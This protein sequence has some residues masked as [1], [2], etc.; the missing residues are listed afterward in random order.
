M[1]GKRLVSGL[2]AAS[3][4]FSLATQTS[5]ATEAAE[6]AS[7]ENGAYFDFEASE[8][9][10]QE[11]AG[12]LQVKVIRHGGTRGPV[13]VAFKAAD[14]LSSYGTD[15]AVLDENGAVLP[16]VAGE[17]PD[18]SDFKSDDEDANVIVTP[19]PAENEPAASEPMASE[20]A[21]TEPA[22]PE[23]TGAEPVSPEPA[24]E[25]SAPEPI[26]GRSAELEPAQAQVAEE[27]PDESEP[28]GQ[29][30]ENPQPVEPEPA[31][32]EPTQSEPG[33]SFA[34]IASTPPDDSAPT[35]ST[36]AESV[37]AE[38]A[39][40]P[41]TSAV[42]PE[43][44]GKKRVSTG[45]P[46]LDAQAAYLNLPQ[47][48]N[49]EEA[50]GAIQETLGDLYAYF[51]AAE[52]AKGTLHFR[53]GESEKYLT[54]EI[55]DNDR[56]ESS[57]V[58]MLAL[59]G[60]STENTTIAANAT[61]YVTIVDDEQAETARF[62]LVDGG[63]TLTP[64]QPEGT[65]TIRRTAGTQYFATVYVSTVKQTA[66]TGSYEEYHDKSVG[67]VPG[68]T[69]KQIKVRACDF[70]GGGTFGIR[71]E[72]MSDVEIG[73]HYVNVN[74]QRAPKDAAEEGIA[75]V[76]SMAGEGE[77]AE[78]LASGSYL[79]SASY[80][81]DNP[82]DIPG[83][84]KQDV[85][86][87]GK[88][89]E[90][91]Q[92]IYVK[93]YTKNRYSMMA[94]KNKQ[95]LVGVK[96]IVFYAYV[97]NPSRGFKTKYDSYDT[98]FETDSDQTFEG[99]LDS[100][101][102]RGNSDWQSRTLS[103][104]NSGDSAYLKFST[105]PTSNGY[106]NSQA[107]L[108]Y[109]Q[110]NYACYTFSGQASAENFNRK[111]YDFTQGTPNVY[112]TYW[113]GETSRNYN[114]GGVT[115]TKSDG[116]ALDGFYGNNG[117]IVTITAANE[118]RNKSKGIYLKGV[119]FTT[120][121]M[122]AHTLYLNGKYTGKNV[123]YAAAE[124]GKVTFKADTAFIK[125]LRDNGV[126]GNVHSDQAINVFPVFAQEQVTVNFQNTDRDDSKAESRGK[127]D[128]SH[129]A[130]HIVNILEAYTAGN[131]KKESASSSSAD[132]YY[133][134]VPKYSVIRVQTQPA[135]TRTANGV[136]YWTGSNSKNAKTVYY[137]AGTATF[138][139]TVS[140]GETITQNDYTKADIVASATPLTIMP[141][142]GKQTFDVSYFP[143]QDI[144]DAFQGTHGLQNSVFLSDA[145]SED[146]VDGG[147]YQIKNQK[148]GKYLVS[149]S[150]R[151]KGNVY[152]G[153]YIGEGR[154]LWTII[155]H[156]DGYYNLVNG[157]GFYLDIDNASSA[158]EANVQ[159]WEGNGTI[160]QDF[161]LCKQD[162]GSFAI[163]TRTTSGRSALEVKNGST[164]ITANVQQ[165]TFSGDS[166]QKW[167]LEFQGGNLGT[168]E[169]G[170]YAFEAPFI[171]MNWSL[172][173][174][175]P[176][177]YYTQWVNMTG[178]TDGNGY[179]TEE[180]RLA[181]RGQSQTMPDEVYGNTLAGQL[182][183]DNFKL[184]YYFLPKT[185]GGSGQKTGSV[186]RASETFYQLANHIRSSDPAIPVAAAYVDVG[187]FVTQTDGNGKYSVNCSDFPAAG[188]VTTRIT[189]DDMPFYTISKLQRNTPIQLP[190]LSK[191]SAVSADASYASKSGSINGDFITVEDDQLT[192]S[193]TVE[194]SSAIIPTRA[195]FFIYDGDVELYACEGRA[196][197]AVSGETMGNQY[198][199]SLTFNPSSD[200]RMGCKIYVQFADQ[201]NEWT[202]KIDL[203]Y[204]FFTRV[205][206]DEFVFPLIGSS[207]LE[208]T[209]TE[210]VVADIIGNPLGDIKIG[211]ISGFD[212]TSQQYT[213]AGIN[214]EDAGDYTWQ[215]T[216][217][218]FGWSKEFG[219][220]SKTTSKKKYEEKLKDYLKDVYDGKTKG[221]EPPQPSKYATKSSFKW[222]VTPNV[223]F[224]LRLSTRKDTKTYFEDLMFYVK[225]DFGV[226]TSQT[227]QLPIGISILIGA[228]LNGNMAGVYHMYT[229]YWDSYETEDAVEYTSEDFGLFKKFNNS[230]RRE[231]YIFLD[232]T[233]S[234]KL[235]VGY[236]IVF[237]TGKADFAFDMDF[238]FTEIGNKSYGDMAI[239]LGWGIEL[240]GFEVYSKTLYSPS[241]KL[242]NS[243]G[244][245][246]HIDFD[247]ANR[248]A[249]QAVNEY[250][251]ADSDAPLT[252]NQPTSRAYLANQSGWLGGQASLASVD[253]SEATVEQTLKQGSG[254]APYVRMEEFGNGCILMV[255][256]GDD[257]A[258]PVSANKRALYYT[259]YDGAAWS[260]AKQVDPDGTADDYPT[261]CDLGDGRILVSWS[262][263]EDQ[264]TDGASVG[265]VMKTMNIKTAFFDT[266]TRTMG[267]AVQVTKTTE[268]D[269][270][271][272][273]LPNAAYDSA[274]GTLLLYYT[275]TEYDD[276]A[277]LNDI[278][279]EEKNP[280][281][282]AY[283]FY[284]NGK[285]SDANDYTD[286]ELNGMTE[287]AKVKYKEDWYGQRFLDLRLDKTS[288]KMPRVADTGAIS[289]DGLGLFA[290]TVDW[291]RDLNTVDDRDVFVQIYNFSE[292]SFTHI[293]RITSES[294]AYAAP[295]F[296]RSNNAT[297]LF[298]GEQD[299]ES[300]H[301]AIRCLNISD[302]VKNDKLTLK[303]EGNN[304]Y[305]VLQYTRQAEGETP[306]ETVTVEPWTAVSCDNVGDYDVKVGGDGQMYLLWTDGSGDAR[307]IM[308]AVY[309]GTDED[310]DEQQA[311]GVVLPAQEW[312]EA[313]ALTDA[314]PDTCY[315][316][317]GGAVVGGT[318]FAAGVKGSYT[319][320]TMADLV[321][322][323]HTPF[324]RL[325]ADALTL[326][327]EYPQPLSTVDVIAMVKN[328][329]L[330]GMDASEESPVTVTF[331][332][333][334]EIIGQTRI[335]KPIAGGTT[336]TAAC[337]VELPE[338]ISNVTF[339]A[340]VD[341]AAQAASLKLV[342]A[343]NVE[344][345]DSLIQRGDIDG[346][347][348]TAYTA[349]MKNSGNAPSGSITLRAR[350]G[351]TTISTLTLEPLEA[352][353]QREVEFI[354]D[355]SDSLYDINEEGSGSV[356]VEI[357]ATSGEDTITSFTGRAQKRFSAEAVSLLSGMTDV[358][359]NGTY[360]LKPYEEKEI[361]PQISG[362]SAE[363]L[364]VQWL[365]STDTDVAYINFD[366]EIVAGNAGSATVNG[367]IVP[368]IDMQVANQ[369][370]TVERVDWTALI[371]SNKLVRVTATINV[372]GS[373]T[374]STDEP[375]EP[376][377][378]VEPSYPVGP[379][380]PSGSSIPSTPDVKADTQENADGSTTTTVINSQTGAVTETTTWKNGIKLE[381]ITNKA[382][383]E[384]ISVTVPAAMDTATVTIPTKQALT[385]GT[386]AAVIHEDGTQE[387][388]KWS[389]Q[390]GDKLTVRLKESAKLKLIDNTK[391]FND[392]TADKWFADPVNFATSRELFNGTGGG[393]FSPLMAM[394][395]GMLVTVL[396]RLENGPKGSEVD[397][398]DVPD[399]KFYTE[400]VAWAAQNGI[401]NGYADGRFAPDETITREQLA[402]I[403]YRYAGQPASS[404]SISDFV[405]AEKVSSYANAALRWSVAQGIITGKEGK[406]LDPQGQAT[407]AEVAAMLQRFI[408]KE[409]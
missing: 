314:Q 237:V 115:I 341:N 394:T 164:W 292:D 40:V 253:G 198:T 378:P 169:S 400:A 161:Q 157:N 72:G 179:I 171:G 339:A 123:Y 98:Y 269:Y 219:D 162:D 331:T 335:T 125:A 150:G 333:N 124:N 113:D 401:V 241:V 73:N 22:S 154:G 270:A 264:F 197:Y 19:Q 119:Y 252:L 15:Y 277:K 207:S 2:L 355:I 104:G 402:T 165:N 301:G 343:A 28:A 194:S 228:G 398:P 310:D 246:G 16:M 59:M 39:P 318:I 53:D 58:F 295:K 25:P 327:E 195:R 344:L 94:S 56:A 305:Y 196:G 204:Y 255:Y 311:E 316:G 371:P 239:N 393:N 320:E 88:A 284:K 178:D 208:D 342:P 263:A 168:D 51:A 218:T 49:K 299:A 383:Q 17:K 65:I 230:V 227:I 307:Q 215:L 243:Q 382:G 224:R 18:A 12:K 45:S 134:S 4:V 199:A 135:S 90:A 266:S 95:N 37:L 158:D 358:A 273:V 379:S 332:M 216:D 79:G 149:S 278:E 245:N 231:G 181:I 54:I 180:E 77:N 240:F 102:I 274:T 262:S 388:V 360:T 33:E 110:F 81:Y 27:V 330:K 55:Y 323:A 205:N 271:A 404:G 120:S 5:L 347:E 288:K 356:D 373:S 153:S 34:P 306:A 20:P 407:R 223:G 167:L 293:I 43:N 272:D 203:G 145:F 225:V 114:P 61:T 85:T 304:Q 309:N 210:G 184:Y 386:V 222:S 30:G 353:G 84:W 143:Y 41:T 384:D 296:Q 279:D 144:P 148:S 175:A 351:E 57:K 362:T 86:G 139:S 10:V 106:D 29:P 250:F 100:V 247:Y 325:K 282:N 83:G 212:T 69:E 3:M 259:I 289:Y 14:F 177:G 380:Y 300:D 132:Y 192:L 217:Y 211:S 126:I 6:A 70:S 93:Q 268:G 64:E 52:G 121:G 183:Q 298:F 80:R 226:S 201:N 109:I 312:S 235:G 66:P 364:M 182:D 248:A 160:A 185:G 363:G 232:P 35:E 249:L 357:T 47:S 387:I 367:I 136:T 67:F 242:F 173:A 329:G 130:S 338:D 174:A 349:T 1:T 346:I 389:V 172:T 112:D 280:S 71:M 9:E 261:L 375:V 265:D 369:N 258:R 151:E 321:C 399:G 403:L 260:E 188:N 116:S 397:F 122:T 374:P 294:G 395:R 315:T 354:L 334:E 267:Q 46:L 117:S 21:E 8:Y 405:D 238:Q 96:N 229:D 36:P 281:V 337:Q 317:I 313:V 257:A 186:T 302:I 308:A 233:V 234:V 63:L 276:L 170:R 76:S 152:Q 129:K 82:K 409:I 385:P 275:K 254:T 377:Q 32:S 381:I 370:G 326:S 336:V 176:N 99:S 92:N 163:L 340:Y 319:D 324:T 147:V 101:H 127:F 23:P 348:Q 78:L 26:R 131:V 68:E 406:R 187:G 287:E 118:N 391:T 111:V 44:M 60:T 13:D 31:E 256:I 87:D 138:S 137:K 368:N 156:G 202:N 108:D 396:H 128:A 286:E 189:V 48:N 361:Q 350:A 155:S 390:N 141:A 376:S 62:D 236:G 97:T 372:T 140:T 50:E 290:W 200:M 303:S 42:F 24:T 214:K 251:S 133:F 103:L 408:S 213:P 7:E 38:S 11:D 221:V 89:W 146:F 166:S 365:D 206:L 297:Y 244:Q 75:L 107:E 359:D 159:T 345:A 322:A 220:S 328:E 193:A 209:L 190:A 191:F 74:I 352:N 142:T 105:R 291:D 366:N 392:V 91:N 285:W 283:M